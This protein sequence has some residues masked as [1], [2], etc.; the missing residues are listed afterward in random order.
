MINDPEKVLSLMAMGNLL[1]KWLRLAL[2]NH[3]GH[4]QVS[5]PLTPDRSP[6]AHTSLA[7]CAYVK[8]DRIV[9]PVERHSLVIHGTKSTAVPL[10]KE[11]CT[12]Y[13]GP[14]PCEISGSNPQSALIRQ[15]VRPHTA[16]LWEEY[17]E[18]PWSRSTGLHCAT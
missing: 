11:S 14:I 13:V 9:V 7:T 2:E 3:C 8:I 12:A 6:V 10:Q 4:S 16:A 15:G 5:W 1:F 18:K 17:H